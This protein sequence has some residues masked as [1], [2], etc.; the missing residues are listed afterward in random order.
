MLPLAAKVITFALETFQSH[1]SQNSDSITAQKLNEISPKLTKIEKL[2]KKAK[3]NVRCLLNVDLDKCVTLLKL[4]P[5]VIQ[6]MNDNDLDVSFLKYFVELIVAEVK[7]P[8]SDDGFLSGG[9]KEFEK[10]SDEE[11][12]WLVTGESPKTLRGGQ[13]LEVTV[14]AF[15][16]IGALCTLNCNVLG[17]IRPED[18]LTWKEV[19]GLS[20]D[21]KINLLKVFV[22]GLFWYYMGFV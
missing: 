12:F 20:G 2:A 9:L 3:K 16:K 10:I 7:E 22:F 15:G 5:S 13:L 18:F 19:S 17:L 14:V 8:F 6:L 1:Q 21:E 11:L 4:C